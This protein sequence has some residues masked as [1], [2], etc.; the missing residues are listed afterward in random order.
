MKLCVYKP[1]CEC[2]LLC[3]NVSVSVNGFSCV[4]ERECMCLSMELGCVNAC[5]YICE[6]I[7]MGV[8]L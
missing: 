4:C 6:H 2:T 5:M 7:N 1:T 3:I 8:T